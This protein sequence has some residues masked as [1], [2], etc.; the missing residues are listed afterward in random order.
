MDVALFDAYLN[1]TRAASWK[2]QDEEIRRFIGVNQL[3][4]A[5]LRAEHVIDQ[6]FRRST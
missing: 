5:V 6:F 1:K 2:W 3:E 4:M